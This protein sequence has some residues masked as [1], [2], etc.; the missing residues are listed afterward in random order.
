MHATHSE[1]SR[2]RLFSVVLLPLAVLLAGT[3][4]SAIAALTLYNNIKINAETEFNRTVERVAGE[5]KYRFTQPVYGLNGARG[6][7]AAEQNLTR[8]QFNAYVASRNLPVEFPGVRGFGFIQR[9]QRSDLPAFLAATRADNAPAYQLRQLQDTDHDDLYLIKYI[10]P[11]IDNQTAEGLDIGSEKVRR[12]GIERAIDSGKA[13]LSG[14]IQLVQN[15]AKT[16][17]MLLFVPV[18]D[19]GAR[20]TT[21]AERRSKLVGALYAPLVIADLLK[22]IPEFLSG[23]VDVELFDSPTLHNLQT[24]IF[25]A[26]NSMLSGDDLTK[27]HDDTRLSARVFHS[28][29]Q[30]EVPGRVMTLRV[31]STPLFENLLNYYSPWLLFAFGV[32]L[33]AALALLIR[34][35]GTGRYRAELLALNMTAD[36]ERLALVARNTSNVVIITDVRRRIIWVNEAFERVTGYSEEQA[37]GVSPGKLLQCAQTDQQQVLAMRRALDKGQAFKGEILNQTR[38][39]QQYWVEMEIQPRYDQQQTLVGFMAVE[40]DITQAKNLQASLT[41]ARNQ[42]IRA[43]DVAELGIWLWDIKENSITFDERMNEIYDI[44]AELRAA[45]VA[46]DY[47]RSKI[48]PEDIASVHEQFNAAVQGSGVFRQ[49]FRIVIRDKIHFIESAGMVEHDELGE[50]TIMTG[51]NRD[52]TQ[53][54]EDEETLRQ[55]RQSA[56]EANQAKSAFLANMSHELRTPMNAILGMLTL[57]RKTDLTPRQADYA[58]KSEAA[59]RTLLHLLNDILDFSKIEAGKMEL[60]PHP[61][62]INEMLRDLSVILSGN[63]KV[64]PVEILFDIDPILPQYLLGDSLC[65]QQILTNLT[66]NA[67]K[68]TEQGEIVLFIEVLHY[69]K[70]QVSLHIG[71]RDTG[72]GILPEQ[73]GRIF[74][75]FGQAEGSITRRFGGTGLGLVISQRLVALMGGELAMESRPGKGSLFHFTITFPVA[76]RP[77]GSSVTLTSPALHSAIASLHLLVID[78]NP[79]AGKL[80]K[81][82]GESFG[83]AVDVALDNQQALQL[84][85]QQSTQDRHYGAVLIDWQMPSLAGVET[86]RQIRHWLPAALAP[87]LVMVAAHNQETLMELD[88]QLPSLLDGFLVKPVTASM[89]LDAISD[90]YSQRQQPDKQA[91]ATSGVK[92][93]QSVKILVV[94]DNLNNQQIACELLEG[95]GAIMTIAGDGQQAINLLTETPDAFDVVLMDLQMPVMDGLSATRY[96]R[97]TLNIQALPIIAMTANAMAAD[98]DACLA[99]GMNAHIGKPFDVRHLIQTLCKYTGRSRPEPVQEPVIA[100]LPVSPLSRFSAETSIDI[101]SALRRLDGDRALYQQMS[102]LFLK[103]LTDFPQR[104]QTLTDNDDRQAAARLLHNIKGM[105]AQLGANPLALAA[106][107][108]ELQLLTSPPVTAE[109]VRQL[110]VNISQLMA[111]V[112]AQFVI[113]LEM[114]AETPI[115]AAPAEPPDR[116]RLSLIKPVK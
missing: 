61:F 28:N 24:L 91:I 43:A 7:Y 38:S 109:E 51:I 40:S 89:L 17:G 13:T 106:A 39:G 94:E 73:Q 10:Q 19:H 8:S 33:S 88:A 27:K 86:I 15:K 105:A 77:V 26:D 2:F 114:L 68:F 18:Y 46:Y 115:A 60:D 21:V 34:Q 99:A 3:L 80:I 22:D 81:R 59:S 4:L 20:P 108:G 102:G 30:I 85:Q 42:L 32:L 66:S 83:W 71:V 25:D 9:V 35:Q 63:V 14:T 6:T 101:D 84:L 16:P 1:A 92:L 96:I 75:A 37:L 70:Q 72:I 55:A 64:K 110:T 12:E 48:H 74:K 103:D 47:W 41:I 57:L 82:M 45:P 50:A 111:T 112:H 104:L 62:D 76:P 93:L 100:A 116:N 44:P 78:D 31:S 87:L 23:L 11:V 54:R 113:L 49:I 98:R 52:I 56:D 67:L 97:E 65:L 5:V 69:D 79:T 95:E 90:A 29:Q 36:L 53:Q 58:Q 107:N